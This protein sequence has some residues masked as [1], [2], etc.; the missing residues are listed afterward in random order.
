MHL[1]GN[2]IDDVIID[3]IIDEFKNQNNVNLRNDPMAY[4]R[5]K[6]S[7]EKAKIEL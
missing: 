1:G 6:D 3:W 2:D 4:Q 5:L 7:A